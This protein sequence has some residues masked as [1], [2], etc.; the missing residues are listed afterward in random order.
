MNTFINE[1][2]VIDEKIKELS[3][4]RKKL[5]GKWIESSHP[6]KIGDV[7]EVNGYSY[8]GKLMEVEK[9]GVEYDRFEG[10]TWTATGKVLKKNGE[11]GLNRGEWSKRVK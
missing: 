7:V 2:N 10:W 3:S 4:D 5:I 1:I 9:L 11:P 8:Q 6:L